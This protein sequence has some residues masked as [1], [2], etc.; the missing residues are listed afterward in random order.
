MLGV[1]GSAFMFV[2]LRR[3]FKAGRNQKKMLDEKTN[4]YQIV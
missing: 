4:K 2:M 1:K 3:R